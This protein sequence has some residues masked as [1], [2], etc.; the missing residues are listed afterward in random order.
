MSATIELTPPETLTPPA[1]VAPVEKEQAAGMVK[2]EPAKFQEL[3]KKVEDF[4]NI[5]L[6]EQ[7]Q[8]EAFKAKIS[9]VHTLA[10]DE[11]R[12]A[13]GISNRLLDKPMQAMNT[14]LFDEGS[15]ISKSLL[16]L[17]VRIEALDPV[18]QGNLLEPRKLL[19]FIPMGT[20]VQDYFRQYQS[21]QTHLNAILE[22]LYHGQDELRKD[23]AAV[24]EE[25][26]NAWRI[27]ERL[28]Q[29]VYVGKK[30]DAAISAKLAEIEGQDPEKARVVKEELLFY[31][32]QKVQ[33]LLTQLAVTIQG[34]LAMDMIRKNNLELIKGVDRATTTTISA[35]RTAV[36]VAQALA[37]QKLVLD[38]IGALNATTSGMIESTSAL[39]K[40]QAGRVHEQAS[41][42]AVSLDKLK[43]AFQNIYDTMDMVS[44]YKV[45]ALENMQKTVD[46]LGAEVEKS[47]SYLDRTRQET[48]RQVSA[49]LTTASGDEI[50][51]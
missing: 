50:R 11:I 29:Y 31:V 10:N 24:E 4:V 20:K 47:K 45:K 34:Y 18:K 26:A 9:G 28:E 36:I 40:Q 35:L 41:S 51:L 49:T 25:K 32:R 5:I 30:I 23:N 17:R 46:V 3:D 7:V 15:A 19:G 22:S 27:M 43:L 21:A 33:D 2:L 44:S 12:A 39:L 14:G 37:N 16:D 8:S 38:Q 42:A 13:A 48:V 6:N 1:A